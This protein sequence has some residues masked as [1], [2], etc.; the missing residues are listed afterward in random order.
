MIS[1]ADIEQLSVAERIQLVEDIWDTI[2]ANPDALEISEEL[3][4]EL[5]RRVDSYHQN[6]DAG[7][8]WQDVKKRILSQK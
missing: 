5:D 4:E 8:S 7:S 2:A 3:G 6:P 1:T